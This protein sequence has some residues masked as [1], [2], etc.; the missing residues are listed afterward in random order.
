M[1]ENLEASAQPLRDQVTLPL[2]VKVWIAVVF[3]LMD[4]L[5]VESPALPDGPVIVYLGVVDVSRTEITVVSPTWVVLLAS[6][7]TLRAK[8]SVPS[9]NKSLSKVCEKVKVPSLPTVP[10]PLKGELVV[11][12]SASMLSL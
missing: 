7:K 5:L 1:I 6:E 8:V 9:V 10:E 4:L 3:S 2:A 11:K 12:S